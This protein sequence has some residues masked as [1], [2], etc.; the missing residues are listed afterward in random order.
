MIGRG[1]GDEEDGEGGGDG[2]SEMLGVVCISELGG[3]LWVECHQWKN[4]WN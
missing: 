2:E 4:E 3:W 1:G